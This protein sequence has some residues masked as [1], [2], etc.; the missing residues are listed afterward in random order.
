MPYLY[1][2]YH[3]HIHILYT[4]TGPMYT[5]CADLEDGTG[6]ELMMCKKVVRIITIYS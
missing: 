1:Y 5:L 2:S 4:Y 6:Q 3:I